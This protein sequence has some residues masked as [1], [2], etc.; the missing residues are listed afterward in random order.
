MQISFVQQQ[1]MWWLVDSK[2]IPCITL[3]QCFITMATILCL[4]SCWRRAICTKPL[5]GC[6][7]LFYGNFFVFFWLKDPILYESDKIQVI[8]PTYICIYPIFFKNV[9]EITGNGP[10]WLFS[11]F[12]ME[13]NSLKEIVKFCLHELSHFLVPMSIIRCVWPY[14][15]I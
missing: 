5:V 9:S 1:L 3:L 13:D 12:Y 15:T 2:K 11:K 6:G 4:L 10:S 8:F 14:K 7:I